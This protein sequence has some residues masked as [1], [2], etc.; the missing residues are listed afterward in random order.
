M[1]AFGPK[2]LEGLIAHLM[3]PDNSVR[4]AAEA[5]YHVWRQS[6]DALLSA[7][8]QVLLNSSF[9]EA[10][11]MCIV[12]LRTLL[13]KPT[14]A[15]WDTA[16]PASRKAVLSDLLVAVVNQANPSIRHKISLLI[17]EV[18]AKLL[19]SSIFFFSPSLF[20]L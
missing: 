14:E 2:E 9:D 10:R 12:L 5:T 1:A 3:S 20:L 13:T 6:P 17:A 4:G 15:I 11:T 19:A 7:V 8:M 18:G 16:S